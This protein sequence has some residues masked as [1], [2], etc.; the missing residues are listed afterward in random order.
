MDREEILKILPS[1]K[2]SKA[3]IEYLYLQ[4]YFTEQLNNK[5]D[6]QI[7]EFHVEQKENRDSILNEIAKIMLSYPIIESIMSIASSDKLKLK[8]Q[9]NTL[10]QSK[11]QSELNYELSLIHI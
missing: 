1:Y 11:I 8:K 9:L 4:L 2:L 7:Q 10:I 3:E 6:E 5:A